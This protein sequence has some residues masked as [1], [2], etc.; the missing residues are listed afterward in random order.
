MNLFNQFI[1][2]FFLHS[3]LG[4]SPLEYD[5]KERIKHTVQN[6]ISFNLYTFAKNCGKLQIYQETFFFSFTIRQ[7]KT[8]Q[9]IISV[10]D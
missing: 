9:P 2:H 4:K 1:Q 10:I 8:N 6:I 3:S 5:K 7:R